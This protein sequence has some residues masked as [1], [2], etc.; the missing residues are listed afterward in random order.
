MQKFT[1]NKDGSPNF[2]EPVKENTVLAI[3]SQTN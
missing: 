3:P 2:G 1:W